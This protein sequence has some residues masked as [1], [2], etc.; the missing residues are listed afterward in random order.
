MPVFSAS[1]LGAV[2]LRGKGSQI[3]VVRPA[4]P[5]LRMSSTSSTSNVGTSEQVQDVGRGTLMAKA[6]VS[7]PPS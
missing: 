1:G 6:G 7:L 3:G 4:R 2:W 5:A